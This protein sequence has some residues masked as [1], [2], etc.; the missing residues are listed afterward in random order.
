M[1]SNKNRKKSQPR[2]KPASPAKVESKPA[3]STRR[4]NTTETVSEQSFEVSKFSGPLPAPETLREYEAIHPGAAELIFSSFKAQQEHRISLESNVVLGGSHRARVGQWLGFI[5]AMA[6][7]GASTY[8]INNGHAVAGTILGT[9]DL[10]SLVAIFVTGAW[11][12]KTTP[13]NSN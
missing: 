6:F 3:K 13:P 5:V 12:R 11:Q 10:V 9:V 4:I 7:L 1:A 8:L 2:A